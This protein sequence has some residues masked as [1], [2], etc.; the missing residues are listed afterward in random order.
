M[1]DIHPS[2]IV[3]KNA[4]LHDTVQVGPFSI[5]EGDVVID[6]GTTIA[7]NTLLA[8]GT[9]IGKNCRIFNGAVLATVP[10]DLKFKN[11]K[12]TLEIGD[13]TTVREFCTLNRGTTHS[14]KTVIGS[15][16]LLMSY[17]HVAH[18]C[19]L[20]DNVILANAVN[21]AGHVQI[22]DFVGI[23]G[24]D[25]IHQFVRIGRHAFVGGG[26]RVDRDVPPYI[27]AAGDPLTYAGLNS[28][29]LRRRGFDSEL[30]MQMKRVYKLIYRSNLNVT[31]ALTRINEE[32]ELVPEIKNIVDFI[33]SS[34]RGIIK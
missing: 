33:E 25:P 28:V 16:C 23:G 27:L 6:A 2:A 32:F 15:N 9:R 11:E 14:Y 17:V 7:S 1:A 20:G 8:S 4:E 13:N 29:G 34:E 5:I 19:R 24:M 12:T 31:Q 21:M 22:Q 3:D 30:L 18:D 10:Q 26:L